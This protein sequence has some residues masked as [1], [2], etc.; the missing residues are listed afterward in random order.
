MKPIYYF[1]GV[2]ISILL[3]VYLFIFGSSPNHE[4]VAIFIGLWAPTII[5]L[6]VYNELLNIYEEMLRQRREME[7]DRK[8]DASQ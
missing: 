2:A 3:S 6:G 1:A 7:E 5:G 4:T 8:K